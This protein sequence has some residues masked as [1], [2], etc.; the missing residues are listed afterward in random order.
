VAGRVAVAVA[1]PGPAAI[2]HGQ[3]QLRRRPQ[4]ADAERDQDRAPVTCPRHQ[5]PCHHLSLCA[6]ADEAV[7][8]N[9]DE[10]DAVEQGS[11]NGRQLGTGFGDGPATD[12]TLCTLGVSSIYS[13]AALVVL[14]GRSGRGRQ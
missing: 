13:P 11:D 4:A 8:G 10:V 5:S 3:P 2:G 1:D 12:I 9:H 14:F 6:V 7:G